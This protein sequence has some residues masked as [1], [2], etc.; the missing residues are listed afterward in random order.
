MIHK[1][2]TM[3][4]FVANIAFTATEDELRQLFAPYGLVARVQ[5]VTHRDT[6]RPRGYGFVERPEA[7]EAQAAI[8]GLQEATLEGRTRTVTEARPR[9]ERRPRGDGP[10]RPR[11]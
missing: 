11:W 2:R 3:R 4:I 5:I 1:G 9:E 6:G 8:A 7:A 10:R